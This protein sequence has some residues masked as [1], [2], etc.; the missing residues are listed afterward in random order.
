MLRFSVIFD[1]YY[2]F[3]CF[4]GATFIAWIVNVKCGDHYPLWMLMS[5]RLKLCFRAF[6]NSETSVPFSFRK[7]RMVSELLR[8]IFDMAI[9]CRMYSRS[10][11]VYQPLSCR[12]SCSVQFHAH[13]NLEWSSMF[14]FLPGLVQPSCYPRCTHEY[15]H[16]FRHSFLFDSRRIRHNNANSRSRCSTSSSWITKRD[17]VSN[18]IERLQLDQHVSFSVLPNRTNYLML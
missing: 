10:S 13:I 6:L 7:N 15:W 16:L 8:C 2:C 17:E 1:A 11:G 5:R 14:C 12:R 9:D 18:T 4:S 3:A